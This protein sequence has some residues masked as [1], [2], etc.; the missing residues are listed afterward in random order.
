MVAVGF[1]VDNALTI[2]KAVLMP[3][4]LVQELDDLIKQGQTDQ[5]IEACVAWRTSP[6]SRM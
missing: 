2:S 1:I 4:H 6:C 3:D 5:A